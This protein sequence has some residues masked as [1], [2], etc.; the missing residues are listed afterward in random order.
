[1]LTMLARPAGRFL[2]NTMLK[3]LPQPFPKTPSD[4]DLAYRDVEF[5]TRDGL[6]LR[7]AS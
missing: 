2:A 6:T 4:Y 3:P 1:M 5:P 7:G